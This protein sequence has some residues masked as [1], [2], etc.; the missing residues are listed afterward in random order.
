MASAT[1]GLAGW[2]RLEQTSGVGPDTAR[3]LL[4]AFGMP[5]NILAAG[6]SALRQVVSER[7]AQALSGPPTSDTL[8][9]IE[10]TA[11]W[12]E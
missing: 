8:E 4:S 1:E 6:F 10:R 7:V 2:L 12:A 5:E 3:K 11:A 9:L